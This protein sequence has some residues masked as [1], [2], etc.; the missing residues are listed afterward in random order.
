[1]SHGDTIDSL[2]KSFES[3]ASTHTTP[4]AAY[5]IKEELTY[6]LQFHP[7]V[8]HSLLGKDILKNFI[9][10]ICNCTPKW[11]PNIFI[12]DTIQKLKKD[13]GK[14]KVVM[15][16]SGGIDS[17][18][19]AALIYRAIGEKLH[20][21][22][23]NNGFLRKNEFRQ[24]LSSYQNMGLNI[25]GIDCK[26]KFYK[27]LIN[28]SNPERKRK[29]IGEVFLQILE[30]EARE[31]GDVAYLGQ[32]T[33]YSDVIE[34]VSVLKNSHPIKSHH[35]VGGL[36]QKMRL[37]VIEPLRT[38]FKDE[39]R[40]VGKILQID[41][42]IL[43]RHPFPGPGLSIRIIGKITSRKIEI[44]QE[45]DAIFIQALRKNNLYD[46]V[47]QA[48]TILLSIQSVGVMG[49]SRTYENV[50]CLRAVSSIDGM[51]ADWVKLPYNFL[52]Q[53]SNTIINEV[54]GVNRVVYDISSKPPST[55]E[56]E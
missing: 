20:C 30:K 18:V 10:S 42:E 25:K 21:I 41:S 27:A 8:T 48:G 12:Q 35:N 54:K 34:S 11:T 51:T 13:I 24:V 36:P 15:A 14:K 55:I 45:V 17:S 28:I 44:L 43:T 53:V 31:I 3:I 52:S 32:G 5:Q 39:V 22:F 49:D 46:Q 2:P 37:K 23:I 9:I 19:A 6:G 47:W 50:I 56:W 33:I 1:M 7:E 4:I 16:L 38:L 29:I 40:K 26:N